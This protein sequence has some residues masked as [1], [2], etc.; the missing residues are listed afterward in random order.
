MTP[1]GFCAA[2]A[3]RSC[4]DSRRSAC[5]GEGWSCARRVVSKA[6]GR[7]G[8]SKLSQPVGGRRW[9][10]WVAGPKKP[11]RPISRS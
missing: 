4:L 10:M 11:S 9:Y 1:A 5:H 8:P 3:D 2:A 7:R 6:R